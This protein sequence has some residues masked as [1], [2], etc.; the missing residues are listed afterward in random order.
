[1][2]LLELVH[3][4]ISCLIPLAYTV[5]TEHCCFCNLGCQSEVWVGLELTSKINM[6]AKTTVSN[7]GEVNIR[8]SKKYGIFAR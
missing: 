8:T 3:I 4:Y 2:D 6:E 7:H 1:M 5:Y